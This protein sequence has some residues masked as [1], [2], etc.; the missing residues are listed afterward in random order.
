MASITL[1]GNK[2]DTLGT[3][4]KTGEK[5]KDFELV[6]SDLSKASLNDY[7]GNKVVLNIFPSLD[8]GTCAASV[9]RFN[10]EASGLQNTKVLCISRDLPFAQ[11]RF[12]GAEGLTNVETLSD[13][14]TGKFGKDYQLEITTGPLA[15]LH[16]R[17][18][19]VLNEQGVVTYTEQVPEIVNEP[20]YEA[21]LNALK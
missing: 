3:L 20:N 19:V 1:K 14:A 16:S 9:R 21:A 8:T 12:C 4:P 5:A 17:A 15:H 6:K 7:L 10:K 13:F 18:V 11:A 2:I